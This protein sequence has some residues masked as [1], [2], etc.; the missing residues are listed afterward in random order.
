MV[1]KSTFAY[2]EDP[3]IVFATA[4]TPTAPHD[5]NYNSP[6]Q[7]PSNEEWSCPT[8]TLK[9]PISKIYCDAC[10]QRQ[11]NLP[12]NDSNAPNFENSELHEKVVIDPSPYQHQEPFGDPMATTIVENTTKTDNAYAEEDP[13]HKKIRRGVRR[14]RRMAAGGIAG[15]VVGTVL[16]C[17][18][19]IAIVGAVTGIWGAR[20]ISKRKERAKDERLAKE[21]LAATNS[22]YQGEEE[23]HPFAK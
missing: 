3:P 23:T 11:P 1:E 16:F 12:N 18:P 17:S 10:Y 5:P 9:N 19:F 6:P 20:A 14:K 13:H 2:E 8:C 22:A 4:I 15:C 7:Q 21:R